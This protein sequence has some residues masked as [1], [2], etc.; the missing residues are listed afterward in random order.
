MNIFNL[1]NK[2]VVW[3]TCYAWVPVVVLM[4]YD[5]AKTLFNKCCKKKFNNNKVSKTVNQEEIEKL[6]NQDKNDI[7]NIIENDIKEKK[8]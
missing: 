5:K 6:K 3:L 4:A 1:F 7:H 2:M 8:E